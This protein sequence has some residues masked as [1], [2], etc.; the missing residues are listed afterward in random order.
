MKKLFLLL[1]SVLAFTSQVRADEYVAYQPTAPVAISWDTSTWS[2]E[3]LDTYNKATFYTLSQGDVIKIRITNVGTNMGFELDYKEG[4]NWTW[5]KLSSASHNN[6]GVISYTVESNDIAK[7]IKERGLIIKGIYFKVLDIT[8]SIGSDIH[9]GEDYTY[10]TL[11]NTNTDLGSTWENAVDLR[12]C[13]YQNLRT[14][15]ILNIEYTVYESNAGTILLQHN[16]GEYSGATTFTGLEKN[17]HETLNIP[18]D[19][20]MLSKF[21]VEGEARNNAFVIKGQYVTINSVTLTTKKLKLASY[22]PVY[23]P[24]SKYAT[25]FGTST[26]ALPD[27]V[28]AYY[29]SSITNGSAILS[30]LSNIPAGQGVILKGENEGIY[31]LYTTTDAADNAENNKLVGS[32]S[33]QPITETNNKYVLYNNNNTP[34]FRAINSGTYLDAFKCYLDASGSGSGPGSKLNIVFAEDEN[35]QGEEPQGETT[36]IRNMTNT[37]VNNNVVYNMNGQRV[38]S[39]Y[40]G[41]VIVNG[42]KIIKK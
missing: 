7:K 14:G 13:G 41:L 20:N 8:V 21:K 5:T 3:Q 27:G 38:G 33:R 39:D 37:N 4:D 10:Q 32:T 40:K 6:D 29:V 26:C 25:F 1:F 35:K 9:E 34:E 36:S 30:G 23:I 12:Y 28:E 18:I 2:G 22:R 16:W 19:D 31:Q 15:D 11:S 17:S 24:A 42:K